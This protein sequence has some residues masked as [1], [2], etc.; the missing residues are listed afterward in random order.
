MDGLIGLNGENL[1][2]EQ[3]SIENTKRSIL[4][5][6]N[7]FFAMK[8]ADIPLEMAQSAI[9]GMNFMKQMHDKLL[10][11]LGPEEIEKL[12]AV[13]NQPKATPPGVQ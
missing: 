8:R 3:R 6:E 1:T 4:I 2:P 10:A 11:E 5:I 12:K 13:V 7:F 9:D